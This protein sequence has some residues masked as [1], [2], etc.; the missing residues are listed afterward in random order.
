MGLG[1]YS[2]CEFTP[3]QW[4]RDEFSEA[5]HRVLEWPLCAQ[6]QS[7]SAPAGYPISGYSVIKVDMAT[8]ATI[9]TVRVWIAI[10]AKRSFMHPQSR[11]QHCARLQPFRV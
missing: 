7:L 3:K 6:M 11:W 2:Y 9:R 10:R 5:L 1:R 8:F 4:Q